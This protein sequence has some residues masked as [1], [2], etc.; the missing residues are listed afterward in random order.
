MYDL[1]KPLPFGIISI[2]KKPNWHEKGRNAKRL[3]IDIDENSGAV[4]LK[5]HKGLDVTEKYDIQKDA[6]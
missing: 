3:A 6:Q 2:T 5:N 1:D 4:V